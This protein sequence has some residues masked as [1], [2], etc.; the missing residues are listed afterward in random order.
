MNR[1]APTIE[2]LRHL[3]SYDPE[4]GAL[5]W[6]TNRRGPIRA[7]D[8]AG[9]IDK[10]GYRQVMIAGKEYAAHRLCWAIH[11][12]AAPA[13]MIDHINGDKSDNRISNL[14]DA[15]RA[16]NNQNLRSA[17]SRNCSGLLGV[18]FD[19]SRGRFVASI[20]S[21]GKKINL[22]RFLSAD[23]AHAAYVKAKRELHPGCTI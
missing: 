16:I 21:G 15:S 20:F 17:H 14:R 12:G 5:I 9:K 18:T 22:G 10:N 8:I 6:A 11:H 3:L 1:T 2:Q 4:S 19:K 13:G 7:G 23:D